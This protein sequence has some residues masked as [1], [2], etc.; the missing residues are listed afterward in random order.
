MGSGA[1]CGFGHLLGSW[2]ASPVDKGGTTVLLGFFF[3]L[4]SLYAL[5]GAQTHNSLDQES[6]AVLTRPPYCTIIVP[7]VQSG[8]LGPRKVR[9]CLSSQS[10]DSDQAGQLQSLCLSGNTASDGD[11]EGTFPGLPEMQPGDLFP[12]GSIAEVKPERGL[13]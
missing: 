6:C 7:I 4:N 5:H 11:L 9:A 1:F 8:K 12:A 10:W 13:L 3:F 2:D